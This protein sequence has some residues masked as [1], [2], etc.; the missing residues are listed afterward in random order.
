[1]HDIMQPQKY[2]YCLL[3]TC[4]N[5]RVQ[6][7]FREIRT[8]ILWTLCDYMEPIDAERDRTGLPRIDVQSWKW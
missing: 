5:I 3:H 4:A 6:N 7:I 2:P 1:M 8:L